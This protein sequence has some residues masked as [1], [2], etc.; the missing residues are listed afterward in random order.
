MKFSVAALWMLCAIACNAA[1]ADDVPSQA[2]GAVSWSSEGSALLRRS[3]ITMEAKKP[4]SPAAGQS[5]MQRPL[6]NTPSNVIERA[7]KKDWIDEGVEA[8]RAMLI[9]C[10]KETSVVLTTPSMRSNS[11]RDHCYRF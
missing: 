5:A 11:Q 2:P 6:S 8:S 7:W 4:T 9:E 1:L 3:Q 10:Q